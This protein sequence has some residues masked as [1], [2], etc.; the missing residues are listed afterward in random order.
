MTSSLWESTINGWGLGC[1]FAR[2]SC[3]LLDYKTPDDPSLLLLEPTR[4][5]QEQKRNKGNLRDLIA[6]TGL[7]ILFKSDPNQFC[8]PVWSWNLT[9]DL[10]HIPWVC[11]ERSLGEFYLSVW[12]QLFLIK[13]FS[14][15]FSHRS[16]IYRFLPEKTKCVFP[17]IGQK[18]NE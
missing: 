10:E 11:H 4:T 7:V 3:W 9:D 5:C 18:T 15:L 8:S 14:C 12:T 6:T 16:H 1:T 17:H 2:F 13:G